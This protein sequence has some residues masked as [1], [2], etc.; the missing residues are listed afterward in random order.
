MPVFSYPDK[1]KLEKQHNKP[2]GVIIARIEAQIEYNAA[3]AAVALLIGA[4]VMAGA[5]LLETS[6]IRLAAYAAIWTGWNVLWGISAL[7]RREVNYIVYREHEQP[8]S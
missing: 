4:F 1:A 8:H 3:G 5:F 7:S 2:K 6:A